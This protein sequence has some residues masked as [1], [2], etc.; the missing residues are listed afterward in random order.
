MKNPF[1]KK[2]MKEE[3]GNP[4]L[5]GVSFAFSEGGARHAVSV[6]DMPEDVRAYFEELGGQMREE[7]GDGRLVMTSDNVPDYVRAYMEEQSTGYLRNLSM[8]DIGQSRLTDM[9]KEVAE[10]AFEN[11]VDES[12]RRYASKAPD[13]G[14]ELK[15]AVAPLKSIAMILVHKDEDWQA[16]KVSDAGG[17]F[18]GVCMAM[19]EAVIMAARLKKV[20]FA[21]GKEARDD[22][23]NS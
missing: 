20:G 8:E 3:G 19:M 21:G 15:L 6:E 23:E 9:P 12:F 10:Q 11:M 7:A 1:S 18:G 2:P 4:R 17:L 13:C 14:G 5:G 22:E 16:L